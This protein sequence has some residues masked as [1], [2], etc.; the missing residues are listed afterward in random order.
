MQIYIDRIKEIVHDYHRPLTDE[1]ISSWINQFDENDRVFLLE[2]VINILEKTYISEEFAERILIEFID[3]LLENFFQGNIE[4]LFTNVTFL[5]RQKRYKSQSI[6][7]EKLKR[8]LF[9]RY[10]KEITYNDFSM[11]YLIYIDDNLSSGSTFTRDIRN[12][13]CE[14]DYNLF[15]QQDKLIIPFFFYLH[16]WG[17]SNSKY[18]LDSLYAGIRSKIHFISYYQIQNNPRINSFN[19]TPIFNHAYIKDDQNFRVH[20]YLDNLV[21]TRNYSMK[22]K[23]FAFRPNNLPVTE[24]FFTSSEA[25]ERYEKIILNKGLDIIDRIVTCS[26]STRPLGFTP[27]SHQTL[28][29]GSHVFTWR[30]TSNTCPIVY[31]WESNGWHPLLPVQ[32]RGHN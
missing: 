16:D 28:G 4:N 12:L 6:L 20:M 1:S 18:S 8:L 27:P 24:T 32:N 14:I 2:E 29:L 19:R 21:R 25:R 22:N 5:N 7:L 11:K 30:N 10:H 3:H 13:I 31:W 17:Y 23:E 26:D 9:D 15:V